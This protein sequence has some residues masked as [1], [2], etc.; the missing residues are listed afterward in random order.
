MGSTC[1]SS[2][3]ERAAPSDRPS[4][5]TKS[6]IPKLKRSDRRSSMRTTASIIAGQNTFLNP[7][8][9]SNLLFERTFV[10]RTFFF[11]LISNTRVFERQL[12]IIDYVNK[13]TYRKM[14]RLSRRCL[15]KDIVSKPR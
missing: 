1:S 8:N 14:V 11:F 4:R 7:L 10:K 13:F 6:T 9:N 3:N 2:D 15:K 12:K 5:R